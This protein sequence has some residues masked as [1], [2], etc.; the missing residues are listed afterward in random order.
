MTEADRA[1][2]LQGVHQGGR[3]RRSRCRVG[4]SEPAVADRTEPSVAD[5][6]DAVVTLRR[7]AVEA[8]VRQDELRSQLA[9]CGERAGPVERE[10]AWAFARGEERLA[11]QIL[12][13]ELAVLGRRD[14][15]QLELVELQ[16]RAIR[17]LKDAARLDD[18][19]RRSKQDEE[20]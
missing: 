10:A 3:S 13:R 18:R 4:A 20:S 7:Q 16:R 11:L 15:L 1:H 12:Y 8:L 6:E 2:W 19:A 5:V 17:L 14:L 9:E